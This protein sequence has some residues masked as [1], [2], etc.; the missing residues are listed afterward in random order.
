MLI[1]FLQDFL[2]GPVS[3]ESACNAGDTETRVRSLGQEDL[4]KKEMS[5][6]SSIQEDL[7]EKE[8]SSHSS[9]LA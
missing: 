7:L 4:L 2:S 8:M 9:I 5:N 6:H 3:K 1:Q